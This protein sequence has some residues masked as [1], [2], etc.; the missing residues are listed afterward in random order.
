MER[1]AISDSSYRMSPHVKAKISLIRIPVVI[2]VKTI[3]L[4]RW[5]VRLIVLVP[6]RYSLSS[7]TFINR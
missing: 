4:T 7:S 1:T 3:N 2:A 5:N 6:F